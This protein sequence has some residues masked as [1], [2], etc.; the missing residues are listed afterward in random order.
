MNYTFVDHPMLVYW[1]GVHSKKQPGDE[2]VLF[3]IVHSTWIHKMHQTT[4]GAI[5]EYQILSNEPAVAN[6]REKNDTDVW[7]HPMP[8][9]TDHGCIFT[10]IIRHGN[11]QL[12]LRFQ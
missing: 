1:I 5:A 6:L 12:A 8:P 7:A 11:H 9:N 4:L 3:Y 10:G 2:T